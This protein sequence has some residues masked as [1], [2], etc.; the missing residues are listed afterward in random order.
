MPLGRFSK[1][2]EG[3]NEENIAGRAGKETNLFAAVAAFACQCNNKTAEVVL[4]AR[5]CLGMACFVIRALS[6]L[7][8]KY[9]AR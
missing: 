4:I 7:A 6:R 9:Q 5:G 3:V 8:T 1:R 2:L